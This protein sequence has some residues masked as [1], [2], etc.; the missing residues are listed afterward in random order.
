MAG[1]NRLVVLCRE[2]RE[3]MKMI[4]CN[5]KERIK[6]AI[7]VSIIWCA[8]TVHEENKSLFLTPIS[9]YLTPNHLDDDETKTRDERIIGSDSEDNCLRPRSKS[10]PLSLHT[11]LT[12]PYLNLAF[13]K[14]G[15]NTLHYYFQ[16]GGL[17][18]T[19]FRCNPTVKCAECIK[20]SVDA[21]Q[22]ALSQCG[23]EIDAY[24]Q[25]DDGK[26]FP[27]IELLDTLSHD[28]PNATLLL[29]FRNMSKWYH[30]ITHWPPRANP[31]HLS[32]RLKI[33][34]ITGAPP[35]RGR[36]YSRHNQQEFEEF[37]EWYCNH[38]KRVRRLVDK[39][40]SHTLVE[41]DIEDPQISHHMKNLFGINAL[42]WGQSNV[43]LN[44]HPE[45]NKSDVR[46]SKHFGG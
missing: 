19:H 34:N 28:Y 1:R 43:N 39:S 10:I 36:K 44:I 37:S 23:D 14:M 40:Q 29:A 15:T 16:C 9:P 7:L 6:A 30:S 4:W 2:E 32:D 24:T 38:V 20:A 11:N 5:T 21:G 17:R 22:P 42:C 13:P 46:K 45:V 41:I 25:L 18:S 33:F 27:Q 12:R 3:R 26:Y 8:V 35:N 31:P